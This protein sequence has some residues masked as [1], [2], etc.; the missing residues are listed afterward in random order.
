M[1]DLHQS[2]N[3]QTLGADDFSAGPSTTYGDGM[4]R[5]DERLDELLRFAGACLKTGR[6]PGDMRPR[7][8]YERFDA[9]A[10]EKARRV[11]ERRAGIE[12]E[13]ERLALESVSRGGEL[14]QRPV[15]PD[16]EG[17]DEEGRLVK[18]RKDMRS[19]GP[20]LASRKQELEVLEQELNG[21]ILARCAVSEE[22]RASQAE[23]RKQE[24]ELCKVR[25]MF[26][27]QER[28]IL[29]LQAAIDGFHLRQQGGGAAV[30]SKGVAGAPAAASQKAQPGEG[31][32]SSAPLPAFARAP[33]RVRTAEDVP[34]GLRPMLPYCPRDVPNKPSTAP[35]GPRPSG[36][37]HALGD[38]Q[39]REPLPEPISIEELRKA[40]LKDLDTTRKATPPS[41][42]KLLNH[43]QTENDKLVEV[44]EAVGELSR[45]V[46]TPQKT[47][48]AG[49]D[50]ADNVSKGL[51]P[52]GAKLTGP[53]KPAAARTPR[54]NGSAVV[55]AS[56]IG[57]VVPVKK[58]PYA[59]VLSNRPPMKIYFV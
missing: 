48:R 51:G 1:S 36:F 29:E 19:L 31:G 49:N 46:R 17:M 33:E 6:C 28:E 34:G 14:G 5:N 41:E 55:A 32:S 26:K 59:S 58:Q 30:A 35:G 15:S 53:T 50:P 37:S 43:L 57:G 27:L 42:V 38:K 8:F 44:I 12:A 16:A 18:L 22:V 9:E 2:S 25:D 56:L 21:E 20:R 4:R 24:R 23:L 54:P 13:D 3:E 7:H 47:T 39:A 52:P 45:Q 10:N 11:A 40:L